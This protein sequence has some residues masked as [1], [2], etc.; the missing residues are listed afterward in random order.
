MIARYRGLIGAA[1]RP[2]LVQVIPLLLALFDVAGLDMINMQ[3]MID[4]DVQVVA[5]PGPLPN[6]VFSQT[7]RVALDTLLDASYISTASIP[8]LQYSGSR[9][10]PDGK[11]VVRHGHGIP[12]RTAP[13]V[14]GAATLPAAGAPQQKANADHLGL[15]MPGMIHLTLLACFV[16]GDTFQQ[17]M[18]IMPLVNWDLR[19][20][21]HSLQHILLDWRS[22]G[23]KIRRV[24][25][26]FST[27]RLQLV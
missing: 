3:M 2:E 18:G 16:R 1:P 25:A 22:N 5:G 8:F 13:G 9:M 17:A 15:E 21:Q 4:K 6:I 10:A 14:I 19:Q 27:T 20:H 26:Q 23:R 12:P 11:E 7:A 24:M